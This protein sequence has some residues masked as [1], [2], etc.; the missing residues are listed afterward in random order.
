MKT[1]KAG[2]LVPEKFTEA[3]QEK[4]DRRKLKKVIFYIESLERSL[5]RMDKALYGY[6]QKH[7]ND[8]Y[9]R[10]CLFETLGRFHQKCFVATGEFYRIME[11]RPAV[12]TTQ[13]AKK[14]EKHLSE[15]GIAFTMRR[16]KL[17]S[18][19]NDFSTNAIAIND[20]FL[21]A[22]A[23][24]DIYSEEYRLNLRNNES[25]TDEKIS[26][27]RHETLEDLAEKL[28]AR[29]TEVMHRKV[30]MAKDNKARAIKTTKVKMDPTGIP[31]LKGMAGKH[32]QKATDS[33]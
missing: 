7:P 25:S 1:D 29:K 13:L 15:N 10:K 12:S 16:Q 14:V 31:L 30:M 26:L 2:L 5:E 24:L 17:G 19:L 21:I 6:Y 4:S 33:K 20:K 11:N 28:H 8:E 9:R 3:L 32:K 23:L 27:A 18:M 22:G